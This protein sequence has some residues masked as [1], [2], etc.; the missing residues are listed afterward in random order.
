MDNSILV[1]FPYKIHGTWVFDDEATGL[2]QEPFV[3]GMS[4]I[5]DKLAAHI[6]DAEKGVTVL[7]SSSKFPGYTGEF[8]WLRG[9]C[10]GN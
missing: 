8:S 3:S 6:P 4:E 9:D 5:F 1:I 2:V 10:G 7:F